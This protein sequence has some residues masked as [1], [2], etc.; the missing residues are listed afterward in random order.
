MTIRFGETRGIFTFTEMPP[1]RL[2]RTDD[3]ELSETYRASKALKIG[4]LVSLESNNTQIGSLATAD[5]LA[6]GITIYGRNVDYNE[7]FTD[8]QYEEDS[9]AAVGIRGY[10]SI[11]MDTSNKPANLAA[12]LRISTD[13]DTNGY[14]TSDTTTS[15]S[16]AITRGA[17]LVGIGTNYAAV[18]L[19]GTPI[20]LGS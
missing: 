16:R 18:H 8:A 3:A 19:D 17:R 2:Y 13:D 12:S 20:V 15:T 9:P 11:F 5:T 7:T 10:Y 4:I 1:G 14:I 6:A